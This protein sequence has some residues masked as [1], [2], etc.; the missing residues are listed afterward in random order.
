MSRNPAMETLRIARPPDSVGL[1]FTLASPPRTAEGRPQS[2]PRPP[3]IR[4]RCGIGAGSPDPHP[5][6]PDGWTPRGLGPRAAE[7]ARSTDRA[8]RLDR[9]VIRAERSNEIRARE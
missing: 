7:Q 9:A 3:S 4:R 8:E 2:R 5:P 6:C 1:Q